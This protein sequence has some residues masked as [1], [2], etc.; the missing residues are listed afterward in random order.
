MALHLIKLW[1]GHDSMAHLEEYQQNRLKQ[2]IRDGEEPILLHI[3]RHFPKR[4]E[5]LL[6][7]GSIYWVINGFI[8]GRQKILELRHLTTDTGPHCGIVYDQEL[9]HVR[10][11]PH[12]PF[13]GWRYFE[14]KDAPPDVKKGQGGADVPEEMRRALAKLGL[15]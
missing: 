13:Q 5:E 1:V 4:A 12:R 3:T 15:L 2:K 7:G 10:M 11:R 9:V 14:G 8:V 6:D